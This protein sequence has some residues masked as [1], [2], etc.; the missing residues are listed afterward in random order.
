[1]KT[2]IISFTAISTFCA[3]AWLCN[4][5][6][7]FTIGLILMYFWFVLAIAKTHTEY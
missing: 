6:G 3:I 7:L 1:M 4:S 2:L 5:P